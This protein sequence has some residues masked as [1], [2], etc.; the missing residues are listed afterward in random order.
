MY[1]GKGKPG[2]DGACGLSGLSRK[3]GGSLIKSH[4]KKF[5]EMLSA[6]F[7]CLCAAKLKCKLDFK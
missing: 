4:P 7:V 1:A 6:F 2:R 5:A 3:G